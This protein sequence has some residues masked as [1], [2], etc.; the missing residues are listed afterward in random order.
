MFINPLTKD[1]KYFL[2]SVTLS[3]YYKSIRK[4]SF[5]DTVNW[6]N[7]NF[8]TTEKDYKQFEIR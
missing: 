4:N 1:K 7:I 3:L 2:D 5:C 8:P 6:Q